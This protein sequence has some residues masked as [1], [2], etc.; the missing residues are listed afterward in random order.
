M[1]LVCLSVSQSVCPVPSLPFCPHLFR[2][3][4]HEKR[5]EE[6]LKCSQHLKAVTVSDDRMSTGRLFHASGP[7]TANARLPYVT[8]VL[9]TMRSPRAAERNDRSSCWH[10]GELS[11]SR[12]SSKLIPEF[13]LTVPLYLTVAAVRVWTMCCSREKKCEFVGL[14]AQ[15]EDRLCF[16][17]H[18]GFD[19]V[20][21]IAERGLHVGL[22]DSYNDGPY[23][24][25][26]CKKKFYFTFSI[27]Y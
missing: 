16:T 25:H 21:D 8:R 18:A 3:A 26:R 13:T 11:Y 12:N 19:V 4:G 23:L 20:S 10:G 1:T 2:D 27:F 22:L 7:A 14:A 15:S 17:S 9:G 24:F 5:R 6:Q